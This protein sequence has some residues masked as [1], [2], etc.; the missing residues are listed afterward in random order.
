[1]EKKIS[2]RTPEGFSVRYR[3]HIYNKQI[4]NVYCELYVKG[5]SYPIGNVELE[6]DMGKVFKTHANLDDKYHNRKLGTLLYAKAIAWVLNHGFKVRSS[7]DSSDMAKRVWES[8]GLRKHFNIRKLYVKSN[9]FLLE[10]TWYP[11]RKKKNK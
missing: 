10:E 3:I 6:R 5:N 2:I 7:G 11:S 8:K 1:M 4:E 9:R